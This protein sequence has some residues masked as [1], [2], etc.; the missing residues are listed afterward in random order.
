MFKTISWSV[1]LL[2]SGWFLAQHDVQAQ[3]L[4]GL[5][6]GTT[7]DSS[8]GIL[9]GVKITA[10]NQATGE[11]RT[12]VTNDQ[13][14]WLIPQLPPATYRATAVTPGFATTIQENV[15][16]DVNQS[17]TLEFKLKVAATNETVQVSPAPPLLNTTSATL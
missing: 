10:V 14:V 2:L 3:S 4:N 9:P 12:A 7:T 5:L 8:G 13:G 1:M 11:T 16:L 15:Q 17:V 6:T